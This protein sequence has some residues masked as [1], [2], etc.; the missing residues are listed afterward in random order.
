MAEAR[1]SVEES[2][3]P[4]LDSV[5]GVTQAQQEE[6][7]TL[8][9]R[10]GEAAAEEH[11]EK[12]RGISNQWMLATVASLDHKARGVV[13]DIAANAEQLLRCGSGCGRSLRA[14]IS[15]RRGIPR[16]DFVDEWEC[17]NSARPD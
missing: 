1:K 3:A 2:F 15:R 8:Y 14:W 6:L 9:Q 10:A 4:L 16:R 7:R 11:R 13:A 5:R 12:L 17:V